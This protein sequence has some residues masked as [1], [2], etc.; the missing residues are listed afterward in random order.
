MPTPT[1]TIEAVLSDPSCTI[2]CTYSPFSLSQR[3]DI[4]SSSIELWMRPPDH[5]FDFP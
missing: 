4:T 3:A 5:T 2:N 1:P